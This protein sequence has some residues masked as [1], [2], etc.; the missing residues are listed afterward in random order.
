MT[1]EQRK[2]NASLFRFFNYL[3]VI[4]FCDCCSHFAL[5]LEGTKAKW[6]RKRKKVKRRSERKSGGCYVMLT[7]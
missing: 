6:K 3:R 5:E 7:S 1:T 2:V 4:G